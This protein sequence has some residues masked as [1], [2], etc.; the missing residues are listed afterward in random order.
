MNDPTVDRIRGDGSVD[1][2]VQTVVA[3]VAQDEVMALRYLQIE[4]ASVL[5]WRSK[6]EVRPGL[7]HFDAISYG[8]P[9]DHCEAF[10]RQ[11][12]YPLDRLVPAVGS[13]IDNDVTEVRRGVP[14]RPGVREYMVV[15]AKTMR[16]RR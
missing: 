14:M 4:I 7:V 5:P 15:R 8:D 1:T 11:A 9:V 16:H 13:G 2:T 10:A 12:D 3:I 6:V